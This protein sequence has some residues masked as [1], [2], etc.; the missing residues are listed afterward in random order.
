MALLLAVCMMLSVVAC[1][2]DE[3][4]ANN[5]AKEGATY[6]Y[7]GTTAQVST[8]N[9]TDWLFS[10]EA[11]LIGYTTSPLYAFNMNEDKTGY[12]IEPEVATAAPEDVTAEYAGNEKYGVPADATEGYAYKVTIRDDFKWADGTAITVDDYI[13][14][15]SQFLAPEMQNYRASNFYNGSGAL[16]NA[17]E[18]FQGGKVDAA[19][20]DAEDSEMYW[21][22]VAV[23]YLQEASIENDYAEYGEYYLREDGT[24]IYEELNA[25]A[26][27]L[28]NPL[29]EE[30]KALLQEIATWVYGEEAE[31]AYKM[32][33]FVDGQTYTMED[34]G[35]I[36]ND[37]H[38]MTFVYANP[39]S[40]FNF[41]YNHGS[42]Y[43][44]N[45]EKYEANKTQTGSLTKSSYNTAADKAASCG[46]YIIT[47][48]QEDKEVK[49]AKNDNW[50]GWN[51]ESKE[52]Q[53]MTTNI[54]LQ[55]ID[56]HTTQL[57]LFLQGNLDSVSLAEEDMETYG[58]SDYVYYLP[59]SYTY[60]YT[61]NSDFDSLKALEQEGQNRTILSYKDFRKAIS[62]CMDRSDYTASCTACS[63]PAFGL[64]NDI[65]MSDPQNSG[66]YRQSEAAQ[67][68][69]KEVYGVD[70][71]ADLTGYDKEQAAQLFVA[72]YEQCLADGN[73]SET[74]TIFLEYHTFGSDASDHKAVD[75]LQQSIDA[76]VAGTVLEGRV[77]VELLEDPDLYSNQANGLVDLAETSW[78]GSDLDP[79]SLMECYLDPN[80][81]GE[82]GY[83]P[84]TDE[85]TITV[86]GEDITMTTNEWLVELLYG[87]YAT[88]DVETRIT[89]LAGLEKAVLLQ[90]DAIPL[91]ALTEG[92]LYSQRIVLGSSEF[93]NSVIG[94]GG[95]QYM[96]YTM[97]DAEWAEY[98]AENNNKLTY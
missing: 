82:Y 85:A 88:A 57:N 89:I 97:D 36:K 80:Y 6:T 27:T 42:M 44:L 7:R 55:V 41:Y 58:T 16:A 84:M 81:K 14:T 83:D 5:E 17:K 12:E 45:E 28:Y 52:G 30:A 9:P 10:S 87:S 1:G 86:N 15:V 34:V 38:T 4:S 74:D 91:F 18:Y 94:F 64:L 77:D 67:N 59:Q 60:N 43:L 98:C 70:D 32:L 46:P 35:I 22:M 40:L 2:S 21:S 8:W 37:D 13:Y 61:I 20:S 23:N 39:V 50:Y 78:G 66:V 29:T 69:L 72:A 31:D 11:E 68:V 26:T 93:V 75:Y 51:D 54:E 56:E 92:I 62:L 73:I 96:T 63:V 71:I 79:Y 90:Y 47:E 65:Y 19:E 33:C 25:M 49:L 76:A 48:Y 3:E 24:D 53:Y 95:I